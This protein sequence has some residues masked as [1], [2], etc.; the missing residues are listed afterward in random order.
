MSKVVNYRAFICLSGKLILIA[1]FQDADAALDYMEE[2]S[3][4]TQN[5]GVLITEEVVDQNGRKERIIWAE[6]IKPSIVNEFRKMFEEESSI[7]NINQKFT[8]FEIMDME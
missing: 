8:R 7:K 1:T 5:H 6:D 2:Y 4:T 3:S